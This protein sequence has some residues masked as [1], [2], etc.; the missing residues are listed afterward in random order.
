MTTELILAIGRK[1]YPVA[2]VEA[3]SRLYQELRDQSG[4]GA[5]RWPSGQLSNGFT[6]SYNGRVWKGDKLVCEAAAYEWRARP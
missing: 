6:I 4:L 1:R 3:A 5:S 2:N